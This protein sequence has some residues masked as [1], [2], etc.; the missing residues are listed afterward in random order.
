MIGDVVSIVSTIAG[1][2]PTSAVKKIV[3]MCL[4]ALVTCIMAM[5]IYFGW[6]AIQDNSVSQGFYDAFVQSKRGTAEQIREAQVALIQARLKQTAQSDILISQHMQ[7]LLAEIPG[8]FRI[9]LAI[10]HDGV[11]GVTGIDLMR[12]DITNAVVTPG[13]TT[14]PMLQNEPLNEWSKFLPSL[15]DGKCELGLSENAAPMLRDRLNDLGVFATM[16]CPII[17][18]RNQLLGA[19]F[20]HWDRSGIIPTDVVLKTI[21][22]QAIDIGHQIAATLDLEVATSLP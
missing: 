6:W 9:R 5:V 11:T 19:L 1:W 8:A 18:V 3:P 20:I 21:K 12:F 13:H 7:A 2:I 4:Q 15:I 14:G 10:I 17:D 22:A 16:V